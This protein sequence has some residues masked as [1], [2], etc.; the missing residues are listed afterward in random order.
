MKKSNYQK[1]VVVKDIV[2]PKGTIL[3]QALQK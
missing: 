3:D 2:I 1:Y